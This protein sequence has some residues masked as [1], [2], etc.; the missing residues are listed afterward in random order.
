MEGYKHCALSISILGTCDFLGSATSIWITLVA[1]ARPPLQFKPAIQ[2]A[3][4]LGL[5][6]GVL[7][8]KTSAFLFLVPAGLGLLLILISWVSFFY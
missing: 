7:Y 8:K 5:L 3:G 4:P 6:I 1:M 2:I